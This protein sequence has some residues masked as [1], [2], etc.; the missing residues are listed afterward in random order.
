LGSW[1]VVVVVVVN[2]FVQV[3]GVACLCGL[4]LAVQVVLRRCTHKRLAF[5]EGGAA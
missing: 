1:V 3:L 5:G 4:A 2:P